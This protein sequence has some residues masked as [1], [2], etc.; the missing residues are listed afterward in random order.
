MS[1]S[2]NDFFYP[3]DHKQ[4]KESFLLFDLHLVLEWRCN[5]IKHP[6]FIFYESFL[7]RVIPTK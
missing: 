4:I 1:D 7:T 3:T 5:E 2:L 6:I